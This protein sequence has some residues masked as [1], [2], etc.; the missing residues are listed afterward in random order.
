MAA[1]T[2]AQPG[3][4]RLIKVTGTYGFDVVSAGPN[5]QLGDDAHLI[6]AR[7][8]LVHI[9]LYSF[10]VSSDWQPGTQSFVDTLAQAMDAARAAA[11]APADRGRYV[12]DLTVYSTIGGA[13]ARP[14]L[15]VNALYY[16]LPAGAG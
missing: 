3:S 5:A 2:V 8:P 9:P 12:F 1:Q 14:I 16:D 15:E 7:F 13:A 11:G 10:K 4:V 6:D